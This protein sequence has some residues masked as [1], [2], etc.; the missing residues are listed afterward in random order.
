MSFFKMNGTGNTFVLSLE[1]AELSS[2]VKYLKKSVL[3]QKLC[4]AINGVAADGALFLKK[5]AAPYDFEWDFYNSD[6]SK[7]EMCGNAARCAGKF[8]F[9]QGGFFEK[10]KV[11]FLTA[12]GLVEV[13][14]GLNDEYTAQMT[15]P[16]VKNSKIKVRT[17][18]KTYEGL[19][20]DTG[21]PHYVLEV[22]SL[23]EVSQEECALLR[24]SM[25]FSP[26]GANITLV[27][28]KQLHQGLNIQAKTYERGVERFTLSCG[29]GAVAA[30]WAMQ[31]F[32]DKNKCIDI[33]MPGGKLK[34]DFSHSSR[35]ELTGSAHFCGEFVPVKGFYEQSV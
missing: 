18:H 3:A 28:R 22:Q 9:E 14:R 19:L 33:Y 1:T 8:I 30:A 21:V 32:L 2:Q 10:D 16:S 25:E 15:K 23:S 5:T 27:A 35:P 20:L 12:A 29:T 26:E 7:A 4:D 17:A 11:S 31:N 34:I 6:G 13:V 24:R